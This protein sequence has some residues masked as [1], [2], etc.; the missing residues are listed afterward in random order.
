MPCDSSQ[1][2]PT[3]REENSRKMA[4]MYVYLATRLGS[5]PPQWIENAANDYYGNP[6]AVDQLAR[7]LCALCKR[8]P[9]E[10]LHKPLTQI[11]WDLKE[12]WHEH[13]KH[14]RRREE[15]LEQAQR[16]RELQ[17]S[18]LSKLTEEKAEALGY[19]RDSDLA[20]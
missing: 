5:A 3:Q 19:S 16:R 13:L 18:A 17:A 8:T 20:W 6:G 7:E 11:G 14:D 4:Q 2:A 15:A 1:M 9:D 10:V 12:W